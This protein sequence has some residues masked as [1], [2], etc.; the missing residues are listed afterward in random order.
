MTETIRTERI[1]LKKLAKRK[2]IKPNDPIITKDPYLI[3]DLQN[4]GLVK[5]V[6]NTAIRT[7]TT[8]A[9][10]CAYALTP[11][12]EHYFQKR[13]EEIKNFLFK[14]VLV[15]IVVSVLTAL[16]TTHLIPFI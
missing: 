2:V 5:I 11:E 13:H 12:G 8:Y 10:D 9:N 14:S 6:S 15:P 7:F 1:L 3:K 16:L 4:K